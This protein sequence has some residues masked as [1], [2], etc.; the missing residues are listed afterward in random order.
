[1]AVIQGKT[2]RFRNGRATSVDVHFGLTREEAAL[3]PS[4]H[5][6]LHRIFGTALR[7]DLFIVRKSAQM[8]VVYVFSKQPFGSTDPD[9]VA[10]RALEHI[11]NKLEELR[12]TR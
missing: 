1:M 11:N 2:C 5:R 4:D 7:Y 8:S 9:V 12:R 6:V 10:Q 3:L